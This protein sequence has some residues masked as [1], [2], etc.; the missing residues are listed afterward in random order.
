MYKTKQGYVTIEEKEITRKTEKTIFFI[1]SRGKEEREAI[2][3][4]YGIWHNTFNE[5]QNYLL[6]RIDKDIEIFTERIER[7]RN[8]RERIIQYDNN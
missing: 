7:L 2:N 1:N 6:N 8:E 4:Y 3:S 5:A